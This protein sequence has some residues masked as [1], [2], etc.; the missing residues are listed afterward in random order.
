[1]A[2]CRAALVRTNVSEELSASLCS[3]LQCASVASYGYVPSS[4]ILLTLMMDALSSSE[5]S[6][7]IRATWRNIPEVAIL[8]DDDD[9]TM[10]KDLNMQSVKEKS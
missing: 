7:L 1:M 6:A 9:E 5:T 3:S 10:S 8:H 2:L 4:P